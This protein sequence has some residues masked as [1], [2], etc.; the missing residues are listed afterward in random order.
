[1]MYED[2]L[3]GRISVAQFE[4]FNRNETTKQDAARD[5]LRAIEDALLAL[6]RHVDVGALVA[7]LADMPRVLATLD[8]KELRLLLWEVLRAVRLDVDAEGRA[9]VADVEFRIPGVG[10]AP[11]AK[12]ATA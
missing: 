8:G 7:L 12:R 1:M 4:T 10:S 3:A 5:E 6:G 11:T 2:R 9:T